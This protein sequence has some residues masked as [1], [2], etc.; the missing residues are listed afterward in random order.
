MHYLN[1]RVHKFYKSSKPPKVNCEWCWRQFFRDNPGKTMGFDRALVMYGRSKVVGMV[2]EKFVKKFER[3]G[4][5][6]NN[7]RLR[8]P[9]V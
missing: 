2:G 3:F 9:N 6:A 8:N 4:G 5:E 7:V 1:C